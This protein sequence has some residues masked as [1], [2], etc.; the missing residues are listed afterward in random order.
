M[1]GVAEPLGLG[2]GNEGQGRRM[3]NNPFLQ[4]KA[5]TER[6]E[7]RVGDGTISLTR[8]KEPRKGRELKR[9]KKAH[10]TTAKRRRRRARVGTP[11]LMCKMDQ[12]EDKAS[13]NHMMAKQLCIS[14]FS[15]FL[16]PADA[17]ASTGV[18][19]WYVT[20]AS[21]VLVF[22]AWFRGL[23][24]WFGVWFSAPIFGLCFLVSGF[25]LALF[26]LSA[27]GFILVLQFVW[28]LCLWL[29]L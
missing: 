6:E 5:M 24:L 7:R 19:P 13:K 23:G 18:P 28:G 20:G 17:F 11:L 16:V 21:W 3:S 27:A 29:G 8:K 14:G 10:S 4:V 22:L 12:R 2:T 15:A 1:K 26:P 25:S 9:H